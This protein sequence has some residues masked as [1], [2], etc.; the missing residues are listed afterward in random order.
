MP[1]R[2]GIS[3]KVRFSILAR[4]LFTCRYCGAQADSGVALVVD[5]IIP[6]AHGGSND[7]ENLIAACQPCNAGKGAQ[8]PTTAVP[9]EQDRQRLIQSV[10]RQREAAILI[11]QAIQYRADHRQRLVNLWCRVFNQN[12]AEYDTIKSMLF[13]CAD[14]GID[15]LTSW[16]EIARDKHPHWPEWQLCKYIGGIRKQEN[17]AAEKLADAFYGKQDARDEQ[18]ATTDDR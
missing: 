1:R 5:H 3:R 10:E 12:T 8:S 15:E 16:M 11:Q 13:W 17:I 18:E 7:P 14:V 2:V 9:T 6:V 4:D